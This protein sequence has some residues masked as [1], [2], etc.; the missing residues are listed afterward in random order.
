MVSA[1]SVISVGSR[2][3]V[4]KRRCVAGDR[5]QRRRRRRVVEQ[6]AA[7]AVALGVDEPGQEQVA[8]EV[9]PGQPGELRIRLGHQ[10]SDALA[11]KD[12]GETGQQS[13]LGHHAGIDD[14]PRRRRRNACRKR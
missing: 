9:M 8:A 1:V 6:H 12:N 7:A 4:P 11:V 2:P 5:A 3:V 14:G 13:V 10:R